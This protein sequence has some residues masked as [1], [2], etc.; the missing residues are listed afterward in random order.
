MVISKIM[1]KD[2]KSY[3]DTVE[4]KFGGRFN[5][6]IGENNI[7]KSTIFEALLL[8]EKCYN[9]SLTSNKKNFYS[10]SVPLYISFDE[11]YFLRITKDED[12]FYGNKRTCEIGVEFSEN[13]RIIAGNAQFTGIAAGRG[14]GFTTGL[15]LL[16]KGLGMRETPIR[17]HSWHCRMQSGYQYGGNRKRPPVWRRHRGSLRPRGRNLGGVEGMTGGCGS[18]CD[19][20]IHTRRL[21]VYHRPRRLRMASRIS[22][23]FAARRFEPLNSMG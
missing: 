16:R 21:R 4:I 12:L 5:V 14:V 7:G 22:I 9:E 6:I 10:Q 1:L 15:L 23:F 2:F 17:P 19:P 13:Q 11:L 18:G 20:A 3:K 8:W